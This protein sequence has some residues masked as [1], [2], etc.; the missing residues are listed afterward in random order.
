MPE[1]IIPLIDLIV[2]GIISGALLITSFGAISILVATLNGLYIATRL[3]S[4]I[5]KN[6]DGSIKKWVKYLMN[7]K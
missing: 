5:E 1:R 2:T 6:H 3:K 7:K 4:Y